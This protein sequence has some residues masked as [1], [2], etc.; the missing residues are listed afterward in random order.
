MRAEL[1]QNCGKAGVCE[2][3]PIELPKLR[4]QGERVGVIVPLEIDVVTQQEQH[5]GMFGLDLRPGCLRVDLAVI[6]AGCR[7]DLHERGGGKSI[8]F[9]CVGLKSATACASHG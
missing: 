1:A 3:P 2:L 6:G 5:I 4:G 7:D 8:R 9:A